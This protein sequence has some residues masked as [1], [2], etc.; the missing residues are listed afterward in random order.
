MIP[1][2]TPAKRDWFGRI[3]AAFTAVTSP[4]MSTTMLVE[5]AG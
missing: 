2:V 4:M 1:T 3:T 5:T